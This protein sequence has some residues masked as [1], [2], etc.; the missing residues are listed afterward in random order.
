MEKIKIKPAGV[1]KVKVTVDNLVIWVCKYYDRGATGTKIYNI[2]SAKDTVE[3][4]NP[5]DLDGN[6]ENWDVRITNP[7]STPQKYKVLIE[8][9]QNGTVV[10]AWI[11]KGGPEFTVTD[12]MNKHSDS[13]DIMIK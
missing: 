3:I 13:G 9:I 12:K 7:G 8:W 5:K 10:H 2:T 4:G 11:P 6:T 1:V